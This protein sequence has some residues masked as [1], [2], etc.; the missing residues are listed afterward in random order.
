M[1]SPR[2]TPQVGTPRPKPLKCHPKP[3]E[4]QPQNRH[5]KDH[6]HTRLSLSSSY[7]PP[8]ISLFVC[9]FL[10]THYFTTLLLYFAALH[11]IETSQKSAVAL[12]RHTVGKLEQKCR[13]ME[14]D[15]KQNNKKWIEEIKV[16]K[17]D[18]KLALSALSSDHEAER[19]HFQRT[20]IKHKELSD[21]RAKED[22]EASG[23][24]KM[25][26]R[27][28]ESEKK[29]DFLTKE[30]DET[31]NA[32]HEAQHKVTQMEV[33]ASLMENELLSSKT[34]LA[35]TEEALALALEGQQR[36]DPSRASRSPSPTSPPLRGELVRSATE[37][38]P[39]HL[40][41]DSHEEQRK[42]IQ[43][44]RK[45]ILSLER[46]VK[47]SHR[48]KVKAV[49]S[50]EMARHSVVL[51]ELEERLQHSEKMGLKARISASHVVSR[52]PPPLI[53]PSLPDKFQPPAHPRIHSSSFLTSS[54]PGQ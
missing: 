34:K 14:T 51:S 15:L 49:R 45:H 48:D 10:L 2:N 20:L 25:V 42:Q 38:F 36:D 53:T 8:Y 4:T 54:L 11:K 27:N 22:A 26:K 30:L 6:H 33:D 16:A 41:G 50:Q 18:H 21:Q 9:V 40:L 43:E 35:E 47:R 23:H 29:Q 5:P 32:L 12:M 46:E 39:Y 7:L 24:L 3:H 31:L 44:Q 28:L 19:N 37:P 1:C 52:P 17:Y 13:E